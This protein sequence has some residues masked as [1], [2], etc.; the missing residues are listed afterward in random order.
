VSV[1]LGDNT[2]T[3]ASA[4]PLMCKYLQSSETEGFPIVDSAARSSDT[5][6]TITGT[7]FYTI[8]YT[9][10]GNYLYIDADM[11]EITSETEAVLTFNMGVPVTPLISGWQ[12]RPRLGF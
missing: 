4:D 11:V 2:F 10:K 6:I 12:L 8:G 3:C 9:Y 7:G 5:T 1:K